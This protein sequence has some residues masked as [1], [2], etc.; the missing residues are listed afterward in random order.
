MTVDPADRV[1]KPGDP[2]L[3]Y[4]LDGVTIT[5]VIAA[6]EPR[7]L[8]VRTIGGYGWWIDTA[9][10][11]RVDFPPGDPDACVRDGEMGACMPTMPGWLWRRYV[12]TLERWRDQATPLR[13]V[14]APGRATL[15]IEG[16]SKFLPWPR[17]PDPLAKGVSQLV[18]A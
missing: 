15:L 6:D 10:G 2:D 14:S 16:P 13:I 8:L 18:R 1:A 3:D 4:D 17:C 9:T 7:E 5:A 11:E 12:A